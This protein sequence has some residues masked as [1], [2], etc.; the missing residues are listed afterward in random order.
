MGLLQLVIDY[1][2]A[3]SVLAIVATLT[4]T[5]FVIS[6]I[7][8]TA[9]S[10]IRL[11]RMPGGRAPGI[12]SFTYPFGFDYLYVTIRSAMTHRTL[13]LWRTMFARLSSHTAEIRIAGCRIVF[14]A[15]PEN[16]KALLATQFAD[17]G[18]GEAFHHAWRDFLG[19]SIFTTDGEPWHASRQLIRPQFVKNRVSDLHVFEGC[20]QTLFRAIANR[21]PLDGEHQPVDFADGNGKPVDICDL[22]FRFTLDAATHFLLGH[23]VQSLSTPRQ[24]FADAFSEVQRVQSIISRSQSMSHLVPRGSFKRGLEVINRFLERY[25]HRALH[26]DELEAKSES[27]GGYTFLHALAGFTRDPQLLRDQLISVLLAGRDT[28]ASSLSWTLYE[29][30]RHPEVLAKLRAEILA[31]VGPTR[32]PTYD[33]LK[34]MKY[35]Q[36]VMNESLRLYPA[37]PYNVRLAL[38]DTTLPRGGGPDGLQ[39]VKVLKD[40]PIG[41]S[42]LVMQRRE[43]LYPAPSAAF[44][45]PHVFSPDRWANGWQPRPWHYLPFNGGPRICVGQQFALTEMAYVLARLFQRYDRLENLMGEV[46]GGSPTLRAEIVLQPGDGVEVAFWEAGTT[47]HAKDA[48][49][50]E[51]EEG[52]CMRE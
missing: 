40:T 9:H 6:V 7:A 43:D 3:Q 29:L 46:D 47:A 11:A 16:I 48:G 5:Y 36:Y 4:A 17:Y 24:E 42:T 22:F 50:E 21:G 31:V 27:P 20:I 28:T 30:A 10:E 18:K 19:A 52:V 1:V 25:I 34:S 39:P 49:H 15:E 12:S 23:N 41:Y 2:S 33:D 13:E 38:K 14:T 44:A 37:V 8:K 26:L 51:Q 32:L 45:P 35:L